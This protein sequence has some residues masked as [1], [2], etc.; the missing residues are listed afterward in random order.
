MKNNDLKVVS[1]R[2]V[3]DPPLIGNVPVNTP[4]E[5]VNLIAKEL[6]GYDR[7]VVCVVNL[8]TDLK[9]IS[10]NIVSMGALNQS[11]VHPR[12]V[13][14]SAILSNACSILMIHNHPSGDAKPSDLDRR[15]TEKIANA[16]KILD[17]PLLDHLII[18]R[19]GYFSLMTNTTGY[20][21]KKTTTV[22][23]VAEA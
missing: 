15:I 4:E 17:I 12:E 6:R 2:L 22:Q 21:R 1:I 23:A 13:F 8:M 20:I 5:A 11:I 7:E 18:G 9:P 3:E 10:M 19:E 16:G 14:K